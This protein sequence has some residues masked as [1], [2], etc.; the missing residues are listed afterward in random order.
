MVV[1][2][3]NSALHAPG[4]RVQRGLPG[5]SYGTTSLGQSLEVSLDEKA[6]VLDDGEG[7]RFARGFALP[8]TDKPYSVSVLSLR[9]GT[10]SDPAMLYPDVLFLDSDF[11]VVRKVEPARFSYRKAKSG[12]GLHAVVFINDD[13]LGERYLV[14]AGRKTSEAALAES[15]DHAVYSAPVSVPIRGGVITW[16]IPQGQSEKPTRMIASPTGRLEISFDAYR[17]AKAGDKE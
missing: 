13:T 5:L 4:V 15:T 12:D 8:R 10:P 14:V 3:G 2:S 1:E 17:L 7:R 9:Q 16:M 11:R 6:E